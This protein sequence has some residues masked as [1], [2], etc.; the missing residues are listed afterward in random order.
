[1][2]FRGHNLAPPGSLLKGQIKAR[3]IKNRSPRI[4]DEKHLAFIRRLAC[5][6]CGVE[7]CGE[8]AHLR[9][10]SDKHGKPNAGVGA[11]PDDKWAL[12]LCHRCHV[13]GP[14][15]QH[16]VGERPF[17]QKLHINPFM[18]CEELFEAT[19]NFEAAS[20]VIIYAKGG[21]FPP[22]WP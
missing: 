7:P 15:A 6:S 3:G 9:A 8:A 11:K 19:G 21:A 10:A 22:D 13:E 2:A 16:R 12:P 1:M 14:Q 17:W 20:N 18:V 5:L 4:H